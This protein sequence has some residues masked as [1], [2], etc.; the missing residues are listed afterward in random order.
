M[1]RPADVTQRGQWM[2]K[3]RYRPYKAWEELYEIT[4]VGETRLVKRYEWIKPAIRRFRIATDHFP[5]KVRKTVTVASSPL[6]SL[7]R[8]WY[9]KTRRRG[10]YQMGLNERD[11]AEILRALTPKVMW[12][13][14]IFSLLMVGFAFWHGWARRT[15]WIKFVFWMLF[16]AAFNLAGLLTYLAINHT[17]VIRCPVC[18]RRR[19]LERPYCRACKAPLPT[20]KPRDVDLVLTT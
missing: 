14:L 4:S 15:S 6:Y 9:Y 10:W 18:G 12:I 5:Y 16:V 13:N 11:I 1:M 3:Y 7:A 20:P 2:E 17:V 19:G 8:R